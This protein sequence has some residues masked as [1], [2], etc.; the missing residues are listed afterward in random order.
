MMC[1]IIPA[2][3]SAGSAGKV[4]NGKRVCT[5][6][7]KRNGDARYAGGTPV[8]EQKEKPAKRGLFQ[9]RRRDLNPCAGAAGLLVF[10]ARPF[11]HLGTPAFIISSSL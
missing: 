4:I 7:P 6:V 11:S 5:A 3:Q 8:C 9:R 2:G 10:E 1:C